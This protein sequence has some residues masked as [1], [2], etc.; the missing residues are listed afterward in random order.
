MLHT[1]LG[2]AAGAVSGLFIGWYCTMRYWQRA[3]WRTSSIENFYAD[4]P[5]GD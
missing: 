2:Y 3:Y 4:D 1:I 5:H